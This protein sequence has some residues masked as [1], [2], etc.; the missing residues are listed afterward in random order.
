MQP[1]DKD[2]YA[3][4]QYVNGNGRYLIPGLWDMHVHFR[5][6]D[7]L[8]AANKKSL[9]L[10]LAHGITT[11]RDAGGDLTPSILA[12]AARA[13]KPA[14]WPGRASS[15]PAPRLTAPAPPGPARWK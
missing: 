9:T 15:P 12:V 10:Y 14:A 11:V 5:G 13:W 4:K 2:S 8:A 3:A 6:G 7:S 1:A